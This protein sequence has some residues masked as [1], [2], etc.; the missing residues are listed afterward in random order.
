M[1][2]IFDTG[3]F[4]PLIFVELGLVLGLSWLIQ[5]MNAT[6][7]MVLFILYAFVT[8]ST[9]SV[10]FL[11]YQ[12]GSIVSIFGVTALIFAVMSAY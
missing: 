2:L 3:L 6:V 4:M 10:I 1:K 11:A 9:L 12:I 8:G 5:K 7:A